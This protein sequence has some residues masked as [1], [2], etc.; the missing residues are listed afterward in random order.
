VGLLAFGVILFLQRA[1]G[2]RPLPQSATAAIAAASCGYDDSPADSAPG[3]D[4]LPAGGSTTY[5]SVPATS[6]AH[7]AASLGTATRVYDQEVP[8]IQAVHLLEHSGVIAYYRPDGDAALD[9][10]TV[11]RLATTAEASK[12][13]IVAPRPDLPEGTSFSVTAWNK[14]VNCGPDVTAAQAAAIARGFVE[15]FACTNNAPEPEQGEDC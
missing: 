5:P 13:L 14:V 4:Q 9:P 8:E 3:G 7:D 10:S 6:G 11:D 1:S 2:P 12:N 15:A